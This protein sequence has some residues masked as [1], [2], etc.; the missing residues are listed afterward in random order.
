M[1][2]MLRLSLAT[3]L[4]S[5]LAGCYYPV[6]QPYSATPAYAPTYVDANGQ[7][8]REYTKTVTIEGK[9][10]QAQGTACR[11]PDGLWKDKADGTVVTLPPAPVAA[12]APV[13]AA[14]PPV[15]YAAPPPVVYAPAPV[16]AAPVGVGI[17]VRI[18]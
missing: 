7:E 18:H 2:N 16:Y 6:Y 5:S 12:A 8:C 13:Y 17:G 4:L 10:Q 15:V 1:K 9:Q 11:Q 14:P 3:V